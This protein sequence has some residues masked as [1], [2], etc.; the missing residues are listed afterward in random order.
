MNWFYKLI[1][2]I[3]PIFIF[4]P[5]AEI[6]TVTAHDKDSIKTSFAV[7]SD[8]HIEGFTKW[9]HQNFGE[10]LLDLSSYEVKI[11]TLVFLGD[12][13]MNGQ[14]VEQSEFYGLLK[15]YGQHNNVLMVAGNHD[16]CPAEHNKGSY[17]ELT[18]RF[19]TYNNLFTNNQIDNIYYS[20][21]IDG[22]KF[23]VLGSE[24]DA[25]V[26]QYISEEQFAFLEKQLKENEQ[27]D[28]PIFIF[29]HYPLDHTFSKVWSEGHVGEQSSRLYELLK[30]YR[31]RVFFFSGHLHMG[32]FNDEYNLVKEDKI[33]FINTPAF[34]AD[35][36]DGNADYKNVGVG[37][38]VE[39]YENSLYIK[40]RNL[41]EHK[42]TPYEYTIG[43]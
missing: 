1:A 11:P 4:S 10:A 22:Y 3:L 24:K 42:D 27:T 28:K 31:N 39:V 7:I 36:D 21:E 25:G 13:T 41:A 40:A 19:I 23:V 34:G 18:K 17:D 30:K 12:N 35:N 6:S 38:I 33:T 20:K 2:T 26:Q 16:L 5:S 29:S 14:V 8:V 15:K 43:F 9:R 37:L 32:L